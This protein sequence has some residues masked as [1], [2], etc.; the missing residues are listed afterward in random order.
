MAKVDKVLNLLNSS[1][2]N[3]HVI[4]NIEELLLE[5]QFNVLKENEKWNLEFG[6]KYYVK[7]NNTSIIAFTLPNTKTNFGL[8]ITASHSDSPTFKI[9][10]NSIIDDGKYVR[11]N[12]EVYGGPIFTSWLD[13]P[14]TLAGR[15]LINNG[16][17]ISTEYIYIDKNLLIIPNIAPHMKP[18]VAKGTTYNAQIDML[19]LLSVST[20]RRFDLNE[21]LAEELGLNKEDILDYDLILVSRQNTETLG[22]NDE[23]VV[24]PKLDDLGSVYTSLLGFVDS[25]NCDS[26]NLFVCFDNEEVGSNTRQGAG[27]TFLVDVL[28][29]IFDNLDYSLEERKIVVAN[30]F[31]LS[32]D[33]AHA[34]H[35]NL[36]SYFDQNNRT[37]LNSGVVLKYNANQQYTTSGI[38]AS[39]V[40]LI[41][42]KANLNLQSFVNRSDIRGGGTLGYVSVSQ[43]SI[44][45]A[46]I[47]LP[48]LAMH[49]SCEVCGINDILDMINLVNTFYNSSL[50]IDNDSDFLVK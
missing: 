29:R 26:I 45:A 16:N 47:G 21:V 8:N 18:E 36:S 19:P 39:Y 38:S 6:K 24:S 20:N 40:K 11:L 27:G 10:P 44:H 5:N 17:V 41:A 30:S 12:T 23:M 35:P 3:Y 32:C 22:L 46:D 4:K 15:V 2:S 9:K 43:L 28:D 1:Y 7:R 48:Q 50:I 42:K 37:Y 34:C 14:L 33:N 49:S 25:N 13:R 31:M